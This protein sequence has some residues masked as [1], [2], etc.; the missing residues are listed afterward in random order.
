MPPATTGGFTPK[1]SRDQHVIVKSKNE[2]LPDRTFE[3]AGKLAAYYS[4][5]RQ[6]PKVEIDYTQ[7][8][9]LRKPTGRKTGICRI[10]YQL[11][12]SDRA[13]HH[14]TSAGT[15]KG[16]SAIEENKRFSGSK[17]SDKTGSAD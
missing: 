17:D 10:L 7:K 13:G 5:G 4:K 12:S 3:E 1:G 14:G 11:F 8:K 2:E 9:N 15:V 6:A 16:G